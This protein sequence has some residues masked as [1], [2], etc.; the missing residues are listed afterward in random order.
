MHTHTQPHETPAQ[1]EGKLIR[2]AP[3]YDGLVN[4]M[5][6]GYARRLRVLTVDNAL[7]RQ[8]ARMFSM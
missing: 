3:Y 1:T 2:W 7:L 6:L 5:T 8:P 4:I